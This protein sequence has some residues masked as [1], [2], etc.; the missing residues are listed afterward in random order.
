[1]FH[2]DGGHADPKRGVVL[3]TLAQ[4]DATGDSKEFPSDAWSTTT[5]VEWCEETIPI[6][7]GGAFEKFVAVAHAHA[8]EAGDRKSKCRR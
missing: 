6:M 8:E 7:G 1:M 5:G 3:C 4:T 2:R